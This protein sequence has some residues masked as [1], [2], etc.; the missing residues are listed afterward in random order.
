VRTIARVLLV[1]F[2]LVLSA[3][4]AL[5]AA[6][7]V[8]HERPT[9]SAPADT[10]PIGTLFQVLAYGLGAL[11]AIKVKDA[12]SIAK[13]F[14]RNAQ[15]AQGD[16]AEGVKGAGA[17]WEA[18]AREGAEN[19]KQAVTQAASEGRFERGIA[20]AGAAKY[21]QRAGTLGPQRYGQGVAASEGAFVQGIGPVLQTIASVALP[22]RR[23]K[24]DPGNMERSNAVARALRQMKVGR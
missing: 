17:D 21:V 11:G 13:K 24:G 1:A 19:Y 23:P 3:G 22:P 14:V 18:G 8:T 12:G 9:V 15:S 20:K 5:S 6:T 4:P 16:Y 10:S 7:L 2:V